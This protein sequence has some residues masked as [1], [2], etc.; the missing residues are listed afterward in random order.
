MKGL[1]RYQEGTKV[2]LSLHILVPNIE[3]F[4]VSYLVLQDC[5][6]WSFR[7]LCRWRL[8]CN[9]NRSLLRSLCWGHRLGHCWGDSWGNSRGSRRRFRLVRFTRARRRIVWHRAGQDGG[10]TKERHHGPQHACR[11]HNFWNWKIKVNNWFKCIIYKIEI[12]MRGVCSFFTCFWCV[13]WWQESRREC[14]KI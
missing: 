10:Q 9:R 14:D 4:S 11:E 1:E 12:W 6:W 2:L 7:L 5:W 3:N 13:C 8:F